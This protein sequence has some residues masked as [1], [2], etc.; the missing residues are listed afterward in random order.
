[1]NPQNV[2]D[3]V[4]LAG[5]LVE[6]LYASHKATEAQ[7]Q[8]CSAQIPVTVKAMIENGRIE[9]ELEKRASEVLTDPLLALQTLANV[10]THRT[11][12]EI[13][14]VGRAV[15]EKKANDTPAEPGWSTAD[16]AWVDRMLAVAH[17]K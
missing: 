12:E 10:S 6:R 9:P 13:A 15:T 3:F 8:A 17:R 4:K 11:N 16:Q 2:V 14:L 1:M 5:A 7:K